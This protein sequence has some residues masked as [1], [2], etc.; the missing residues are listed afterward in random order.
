MSKIKPQNR[1][2]VKPQAAGSSSSERCRL[3]TYAADSRWSTAAMSVTLAFISASAIISR[4]TSKLFFRSYMSSFLVSPISDLFLTI[5]VLLF[6]PVYLVTKKS[7]ELGTK[8]RQLEASLAA[9]L[10]KTA[11]ERQGRIRAQQVLHII[12]SSASLHVPV[13]LFDILVSIF[14]LL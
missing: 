6:S 1:K 12:C 11:A 7:R 2:L 13:L 3:M 14:S 8:V 5:K 9:S 4:K 10:K